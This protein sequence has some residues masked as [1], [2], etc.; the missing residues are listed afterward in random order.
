MNPVDVTAP[1]WKQRWLDPEVK[2]CE[3]HGNDLEHIPAS[4]PRQAKNMDRLL[5]NI[6][7]YRQRRSEAAYFGPNDHLFRFRV[8]TRFGL[9]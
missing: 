2:V 9:A 4:I 6:S 3:E 5:A 7:K 1:R 8:I